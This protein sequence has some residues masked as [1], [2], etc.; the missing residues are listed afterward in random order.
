MTPES[1]ALPSSSAAL[2]ELEVPLIAAPMAGGPSSPELVIEVSRAGGLGMLAGG[3][4]PVERIAEQIA[5]VREGLRDAER[6]FGVNLFVPE[7]APTDPAELAEFREQWSRTVAS[8]DADLSELAA[9]QPL[10]QWSDDGWAQKI[11]LLLADPVPVVSFTFG[12]PP[13]EVIRSLQGLGTAVLISVSSAAEA[14][15]AASSRPDALVL[16]GPDAG[17]HRFTLA[18]DAV[19]GETPLEELLGETLSALSAS[20]PELPVIAAGGIGSRADAARLL[21]A[22]AFAVQVGTLF[23]T[24]AEAGTGAVHRE[25][26]LGAAADPSAVRTVVTR[27]FSGRPARSLATAYTDAMAEHEIAGYPQVNTLAAPVRRA[28]AAAGRRE[29]THLWAGAAF[30]ACTARPA[31]EIVEDFRGL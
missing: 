23:V 9:A 22:G 28:A 26:V 25:A 15:R 27:A 2:S 31:A 30:A 14:A 3:Y 6:P 1:S 19:P 16:Q 17:G 12:V 4:L 10:P 13:V 11:A 29:L 5:A 7:A 21:E 24:A 8:L 18:Q 20:H